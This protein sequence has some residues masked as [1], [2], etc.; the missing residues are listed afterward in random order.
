MCRALDSHGF[1]DLK[2]DFLTHASFTSLY[3]EDDPR[4]FQLGTPPRLLAS[5]ERTCQMTPTSKHIVEDI[6]LL[7]EVL[8]EIIEAFGYGCKMRSSAAC[9]QV[10][11]LKGVV[12]WLPLST[13]ASWKWLPRFRT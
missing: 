13:S 6:E 7:N 2:A 5:V 4:H 10:A 11:A 3:P 12:S 1:V 8:G 9:A